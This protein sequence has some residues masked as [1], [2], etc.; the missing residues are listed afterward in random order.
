MNPI[1]KMFA[2]SQKKTLSTG[3]EIDGSFDCQRDNCN[4]WADEAK[5]SPETKLLVWI[6][7]VCEKPSFIEDFKI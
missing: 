5:Y 3:E 1:D 2:L 7:T 6:C 4:G